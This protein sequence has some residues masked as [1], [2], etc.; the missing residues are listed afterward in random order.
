MPQRSARSTLRVLLLVQVDDA[1]H[2]HPL[3]A[4]DHA[5]AL[6][7]DRQRRARC[8]PHA[9][10]RDGIAAE[11]RVVLEGI[12]SGDGC[13]P[14]GRQELHHRLLAARAAARHRCEQPCTKD[15]ATCGLA[16]SLRRLRIRASVHVQ[17][18][19]VGEVH[20][21][22]EAPVHVIPGLGPF[23]ANLGARFQHLGRDA[24]AA[25]LRVAVR[26]A[27]VLL[28]PAVFVDGLDVQV[29]VRVARLE[30]RDLAGDADRLLAVEVRRKA[31]VR[32]GDRRE[33]CG[34]QRCDA[35]DRWHGLP[36]ETRRHLGASW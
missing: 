1:L 21:G 6:S 29:A 27:H 16:R 13:L 26:F 4:K 7:R 17:R 8:A 23:D 22:E 15:V 20:V 25:E 2:V 3:V 28:R 14:G 18:P 10:D 30:L 11:R 9:A 12:V 31:V 32:A 19:A 35:A 24:V 5:I 34:D 33:R 36:P